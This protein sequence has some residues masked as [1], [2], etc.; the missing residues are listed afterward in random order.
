MVPGGL[1]AQSQGNGG[2]WRVG[3]G[4]RACVVPELDPCGGCG[5]GRAAGVAYRTAGAA[6]P[7]V[8]LC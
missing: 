8:C 2:L 7:R 5:A 3:E 6:V 4:G 1:P